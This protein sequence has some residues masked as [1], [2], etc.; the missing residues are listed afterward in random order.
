MSALDTALI[1]RDILNGTFE[2]VIHNSENGQPH[3]QAIAKTIVNPNVNKGDDAVD[4]L[5]RDSKRRGYL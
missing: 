1:K 3:G 4:R 5:Q 2:V